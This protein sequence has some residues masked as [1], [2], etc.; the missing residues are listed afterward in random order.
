MMPSQPP[1]HNIGYDIDPSLTAIQFMLSPYHDIPP[2]ERV[3][4]EQ[5]YMMFS[6][7]MALGNIKRADILGLIISFDE[8]CMLL[9]MGLYEEARQI[10]GRELMKMQATRSVGGFQTLFGKGIDRQESIQ[11]VLMKKQKRGLMG[12]L[13]G[14]FK[15]DKSSQYPIETGWEAPE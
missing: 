12:R 11:R 14:A 2:K 3:N 7:T 8:V 5:F 10:M 6:H 4:F 1:R 9:E 15:K 13:G